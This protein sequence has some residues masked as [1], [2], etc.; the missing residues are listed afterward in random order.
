[1]YYKIEDIE[2]DNDNNE[3]EYLDETLHFLDEEEDEDVIH[4]VI[5]QRIEEHEKEKNKME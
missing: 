3:Y 2:D 4:D 5:N 1:M